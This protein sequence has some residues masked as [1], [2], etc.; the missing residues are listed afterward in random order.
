[1]STLISSP[2]KHIVSKTSCHMTAVQQQHT[3][4]WLQRPTTAE[5]SG[6]CGNAGAKLSRYVT[7]DLVI[8]MLP[9]SYYSVTCWSWSWIWYSHNDCFCDCDMMTT[10]C[11]T[12]TTRYLIL[13]LLT[14]ISCHNV[15]MIVPTSSTTLMHCTAMQMYLY[16]LQCL[17]TDSVTISATPAT[18]APSAAVHLPPMLPPPVL[19]APQLTLIV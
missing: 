2:S 3:H 7:P 10:K 1:M 11:T 6:S 18:H 16:S 15:Y 9:L 8:A 5:A 19:P 17:F 13:L 14:L 4:Q 12:S